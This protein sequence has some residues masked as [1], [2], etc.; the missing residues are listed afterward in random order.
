MSLFSNIKNLF[1]KKK[2]FYCIVWDGKTMSY[3]NL[4]QKEID[5]KLLLN[6]ELIITKKDEIS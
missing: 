1:E 6:K 3:L 5:K 2:V 4:S